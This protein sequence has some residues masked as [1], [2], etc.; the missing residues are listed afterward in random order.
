MDRNSAIGLTLIAVLLLVYFNFFAPEP[1]KETPP[2]VT[3][4]K[5][6]STARATQPLD[7]ASAKINPAAVIEEKLTRV[8]T[9]DLIISFSNHGGVIKEVELKNFKT[10]YHNPL[11]VSVAGACAEFIEAWQ[12]NYSLIAFLT[13][14]NTFAVISSLCA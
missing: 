2:I 11:C 13:F 4:E 7:T 1:P 14:S 12:N 10:Y 3:S 8:E 5:V 6:D 9:N